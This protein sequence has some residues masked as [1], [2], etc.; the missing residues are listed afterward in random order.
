MFE[1]LR[2]KLN[3]Y[4]LKYKINSKQ[5]FAYQIM[6]ILMNEHYLSRS[7]IGEIGVC[8]NGIDLKFSKE[9][10]EVMCVKIFNFI[11]PNYKDMFLVYNIDEDQL[12]ESLKELVY[13][14][15]LEIEI[16][17]C[18]LIE[19]QD[20][21]EYFFKINQ[22]G[23]R[24]QFNGYKRQELKLMEKANLFLL[25]T[26]GYYL[27]DFC[28]KNPDMKLSFFYF[29][30]ALLIGFSIYFKNLTF[31]IKSILVALAVIIFIA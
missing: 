5:S 7:N 22:E 11:T 6:L 9:E 30:V 19:D 4:Y 13:K 29:P 8:S 2:I 15:L 12:I 26:L 10:Y 24:Y 1:N 25:L 17:L 23:Y 16:D 20:K 28:F 3:E 18:E 14:N 27:L 31:I 21:K